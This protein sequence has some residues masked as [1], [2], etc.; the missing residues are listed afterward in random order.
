MNWEALEQPLFP[1]SR[2]RNVNGDQLKQIA[3][4]IAQ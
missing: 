4:E 2:S 3:W 1:C